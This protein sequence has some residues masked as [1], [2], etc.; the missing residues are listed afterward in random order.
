MRK[1]SACGR[2]FDDDK[3]VYCLN[4]GAVLIDYNEPP[5]TVQYNSSLNQQPY[6]SSPAPR[7]PKKSNNLLILG[8]VGVLMLGLF[9][10]V[11]MVIGILV[12]LKN[13][14]NANI[15]NRRTS[16][17]PVTLASNAEKL[18][19][20]LKMAIN[21][22][23][24]AQVTANSTYNTDALRN[25][26]SGEALRSFQADAENLKKMKI[27]Q[28]ST[29]KAQEFENFKVNETGTEAEV[30]VV[31]TWETYIFQTPSRKCLGY[32]PPTPMPQTVYLKKS[33]RGWLVDAT[34]HDNKTPA[35]PQPCPKKK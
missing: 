7:A 35:T 27:Y 13:D 15:A 18:Q 4:D 19:P 9:I 34:I 6:S 17:T 22:A 21:S 31:E 23:N 28:V 1:C 12:N 11:L 16:P 10:G 32:L 3:L 20:E 33:P 14:K 5:P 29:I 26:Y 8:I 25:Y 30:R 2:I 24:F